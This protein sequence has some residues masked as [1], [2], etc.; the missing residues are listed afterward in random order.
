MLY[1]V[2]SYC[3]VA[4]L[5]FL[6][7]VDFGPVAKCESLDSMHCGWSWVQPPNTP[8]LLPTTECKNTSLEAKISDIMDNFKAKIS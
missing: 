6:V 8:G 1:H 4:N 7:F 3:N 5:I 2:W